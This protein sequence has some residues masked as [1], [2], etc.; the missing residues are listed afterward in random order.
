MEKDLRVDYTHLQMISTADLAYLGDAVYE[1]SIRKGLILRGTNGAGNLS[2][3]AAKFVTA[4]NQSKFLHLL[5]DQ[6]TEDELSVAKRARNKKPNNIP[7]H[8][9]RTEYIYA[10][11]LE[12]VFGYLSLKEDEKRIIQLVEMIFG[13]NDETTK[14]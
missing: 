4:P 14:R 2:N 10:T 3:E 12:A 13:I 7:K 8:A 9:T 11:A 1:L 6:L 5:W